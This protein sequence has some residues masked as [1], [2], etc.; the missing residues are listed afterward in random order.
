MRSKLDTFTGFL[1]LFITIAFNASLAVV[2]Y[3]LIS[4]KDEAVV[5]IVILIFII[6]SSLIC[7]M[8][9]FIRR[10]LTEEAPVKE[11]L[12]ATKKMSTGDFNI[13]L[14]IKHRNRFNP[15]DSIKMD[16]NVLA[17]ELSKNEVLKT[18]FISNVS[19]EIKTPLSVIQTYAQALNNPKLDEEAK[20]KYLDTLQSSC[21]KLS[22][23]VTN[24]LKLNKLENGTIIPE[25][26]EFNLT[27]ALTDQI[28]SFDHLLEEKKIELVCDL[29]ENVIIKN[30]KSYLDIIWSNLISNAI[31]FSDSKGRI[32]IILKQ[33][34]DKVYFTIEDNGC[35]MSPEEGKHIFDKFYQA[36]TSHSK[37]GNGLGLA[38]VKKVIDV[39]G[40]TISVKSEVGKKTKFS[41]VLEGRSNG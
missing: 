5:A 41:V 13:D 18:D 39:L 6:C 17:Q 27:E 30:E 23:L 20:M 22:N 38:L 34:N 7:A 32:K 15:Y 2:V 12:E 37:E 1:I 36:D 11:I 25:F 31:K 35:G 28:I 9:D 29:E 40:G 19:H 33:Q 24:I 21:K 4:D 26:K 10:K 14:T 3:S 8:I 16:L